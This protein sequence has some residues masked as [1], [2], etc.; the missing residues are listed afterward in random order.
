VRVTGINGN[1]A[2]KYEAFVS[3]EEYTVL[4]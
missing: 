3:P 4:F 2:T 1:T